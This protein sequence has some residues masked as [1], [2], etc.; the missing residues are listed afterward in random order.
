MNGETIWGRKNEN[1]KFAE[2]MQILPFM[3]RCCM[4]FTSPKKISEGS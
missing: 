4:N 2:R 1:G 3:L